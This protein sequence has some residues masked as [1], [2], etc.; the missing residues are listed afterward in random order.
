MKKKNITDITISQTL[1][2]TF[3]GMVEAMTDRSY[4]IVDVYRDRL[5]INGFG[6][7]E[8]RTL[9]FGFE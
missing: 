5:V 7:Q 8:D 9:E 4:G 1:D 3:K 2:L 6:D